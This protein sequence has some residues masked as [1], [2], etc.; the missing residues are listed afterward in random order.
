MVAGFILL[1]LAVL[2]F[3]LIPRQPSPPT[4]DN[5]DTASKPPPQADQ[6]PLTDFLNEAMFLQAFKASD[7]PEANALKRENFNA[8]NKLMADCPGN[9]D[10]LFLIGNFYQRHGS[11]AMAITCWKEG[12]QRAPNNPAAHLHLGWTAIQ[13][14]EFQQAIGHYEKA[15]AIAPDLPSA[16]FNMGKAA[17]ALGLLDDAIAAFKAELKQSPHSAIVH[18]LLGQQFLQKKDYLQAKSCY[19]RAIQRDPD[20]ANAHYGMVKALTRLKQPEA[21]QSHLQQFKRLKE[22]DM[23]MLK[24]EDKAFD[25]MKSIRKDVA[26]TLLE[27][28]QI[29]K[30]AGHADKAE[31][32]WLKA[33][34]IHPDLIPPRLALIEMFKRDQP[35]QAMV[36]YQALTRIQP[37]N[38]LWLLRLGKLALRLKQHKTAEKALLKAIKLKKEE[39]TIYSQLALVYLTSGQKLSQ[40]LERASHAVDL[41]PTAPHYDLLGWALYA[42]GY[43]DRAL[44]AL[45][46]AIDLDPRNP[47]YRSRYQNFLQKLKDTQR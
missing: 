29:Y 45:Q 38:H 31:T 28:G 43:N 19:E 47:T 46:Q 12:I 34:A 44:E 3:V 21:A 6:K 35:G 24:A 27:A 23:A 4:D 40:A 14:G 42:N 25:D 11:S 9:P 33:T 41:A 10:I 15:L 1:A 16:H 22:K 26:E 36:H 20:L 17:M 7:T 2:A 39:A 18:F 37:N 13:K 5:G 30:Q 8:L 32:L